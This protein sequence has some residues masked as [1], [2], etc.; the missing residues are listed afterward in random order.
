[1]AWRSRCWA[2]VSD[3]TASL[4]FGMELLRG[5]AGA[6]EP[7]VMRTDCRWIHGFDESTLSVRS[8]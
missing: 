1:M 3:G 6:I 2:G 4:A 7:A 5:D 8:R